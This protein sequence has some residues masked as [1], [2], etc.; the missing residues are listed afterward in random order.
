MAGIPPTVR[1][2]G[3]HWPSP[4]VGVATNG[5]TAAGTGRWAGPTGCVVAVLWVGA[6]IAPCFGFPPLGGACQVYQVF[7]AQVTRPPPPWSR[8]H[9][10][11]R[12]PGVLPSA[13]LVAA[14]PA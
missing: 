12:A 1:P 13:W 11:R 9:S 5:V 4:G 10:V 14:D 2:I 8:T 3:C 7:S 6:G